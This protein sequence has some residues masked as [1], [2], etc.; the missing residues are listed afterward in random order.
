VD[1]AEAAGLLE[2]LAKVARTATPN[3]GNGVG[4]IPDAVAVLQA[5]VGQDARQLEELATR[6]GVEP[7]YLATLGQLLALPLLQACYRRAAPFLENLT[8]DQ[9][10][11]PVCAGWPVLAEVRGVEMQRWLRCGRCGAGWQ[12]PNFVCAF[13]GNNDYKTLGYLATEAARESR[14]AMTCE[15]C[16]GYLKTVATQLPL[17]ADEL[18]LRDVETLELDIAALE[19][20]Y[21]RPESPEVRLDVKVVPM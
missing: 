1:A 3:G 19:K 5:S 2:R 12:R 13:C 10:Y 15:S 14:Q 8:W 6:F 16:R 20:G 11:C 21:G 17:D 9:G 4:D 7:P 18:F